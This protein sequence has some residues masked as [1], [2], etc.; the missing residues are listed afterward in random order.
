ML[1]WDPVTGDQHR[2]DI[3]PGLATHAEKMTING[4]VL[5]VGGGAHFQVVLAVNGNDDKKHEQ[6]LAR[7]YSSA[8][9]S[10]G[11]LISTRLPSEVGRSGCPTL[12][13]TGKTAVMA[14]GSLYWILAGSF[15][16][17]LE[18]DLE[19]QSLGVIQ[20]PVH[21]LEEG[22][23]QFSIMRAEGGGLGLLF[24][25]G[26]SFELWKRKTDCDGVDSWMLGRTIELDKLLCLD[27]W[28]VLVLGYAENNNVVFFW[29]SGSLFMVH[30]E[31]LHF[32]TLFQT[33]I[34][35]HYH[36]FESV[37]SAGIGLH[38]GG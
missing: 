35:P 21:M 37:Y 8:I 7:V 30:L 2:L 4:A 1:V 16:G 28:R 10:W 29:T 27:I 22:Y 15:N 3:P 20:V 18:F 12:V 38:S 13:F 9:G 36:P 31:S 17:I 34:I 5:R 32:K 25:T 14:W 23:Y 11:D 6:V 33:T 26:L 19:K 24:Q